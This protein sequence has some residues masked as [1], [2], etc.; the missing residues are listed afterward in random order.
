MRIKSREKQSEIRTYDSEKL[1]KSVLIFAIHMFGLVMRHVVAC[2][3]RKNGYARTVLLTYAL[4][5]FGPTV[6]FAATPQYINVTGSPSPDVTG[7]YEKQP[8]TLGSLGLEYWMRQ[9]GAYY[10]YSDE[11]N[12]NYFWNIDDDTDDTNVYFY[13]SPSYSDAGNFTTNTPSPDAVSSW[14]ACTDCSPAGAG[15][16]T[17][18]AYSP[19]SPEINVLGNSTNINDG[20]TTP[21]PSNGTAFGYTAVS[22]DTISKTFTIENTGGAALTLG[23][24]AVSVSGT[25]S[26]DFTVTTQPASTVASSGTTTFTI[27]FDPSATGTR[28]AQLSIAN[29]DSDENPYNFSIRGGGSDE[30]AVTPQFLV[31]SGISDPSAANG[32]YERQTGTH[33]FF[34]HEYWK[35]E[36]EAYYLYSD[37][38]SDDFYWNIDNDLDD[39]DV[40]F[41]SYDDYN[42][43]ANFATL[44]SPDAI[45]DWR[46][47]DGSGAPEVA[48]SGVTAP[49]INV[50][51]NDTDIATGDTTPRPS[52]DT[53]FGYMTVPS[54]TLS[55]TFT[56]LNTGGDTLTLGVDSVTISGAGASD[57]TITA[58]PAST[59]ASSGTTTF[60]ITFNPSAI[61]TRTAQLSIANDDSDEN[62]YTFSI[63]GGGVDE[64][65]DTPQYIE[66]SGITTPATA[67]GIY[68]KQSD[69]HGYFYH[70]YWKHQTEAYYLYSDAYDDGFYWDIDS[71]FNDDDVL[72]YSDPQAS[73]DQVSPDMV[74]A[75]E[76]YS[77][78]GTPAV[79]IYTTPLP[80]INI[81][82][83]GVDIAD[84]ASS[85]STADDTDFG[86][87]AT[88][89]GTIAK[90]FTIQNTGTAILNLGGTPIVSLTGDSDFSVSA[91]PS[92]SSVAA[93]N[94][95]TFTVTFAPSSDG[96]HTAE[97]SIDNDDGDENPY[98]FTIQG[99]GYTPAAVSNVSAAEADGTYGDGDTIDITITFDDTVNVTGTPQLT[100]E[101]GDTDAVVDYSSGSG[102]AILT[103]IYT[104]AASHRTNDLAYTATAALGL[105]GG[106]ITDSSG[107]IALIALPA[108]G[109]AGSL[110]ANKDLYI[111]SPGIVIDEDDGLSVDESLSDDTFTVALRAQ[112]ENDVVLDLASGDTGEAD[113]SP[114]SL[115]FTST[116]WSTPRTVTITGVNDYL[117]DGDQ[118]TTIGIAVNDAASD[119]HFNGLSGSVSVTTTDDDTAGFTITET[120]GD[121]IVE[122]AGP[123]TDTFTV[124]LDARPDTDVVLS[125]TSGDSTEAAVSPATLTFT[126]S[127]WNTPQTVTVTGVDDT[128][129]DESAAH[130][131]TIAV[132][133]A[134]SDDHFDSLA[135]QTVAVTTINDDYPEISV[136]GT[137]VTEVDGSTLS[138]TFKVSLSDYYNDGNVTVDYKTTDGTAEA[139]SDYTG[140][141]TTVL[142]FEPVG[143]IEKEITVTVLDDDIDEAT[144]EFYLDLSNA[145][146]GTIVTDRAT[147]TIQ[148]DDTSTITIS[149][150]TLAEGDS[151]AA[152]AE[153]T[154]SLACANSR[155]VTVDYAT[156]DNE[157]V[158]G[159]DYSEASGTLTIAAGET[160]GTIQ[161]P[162]TGDILDEDSETFYLDLSNP[163]NAPVS[164]A[165][166]VCTITDDDTAALSIDDT[167]VTEGDSG[168]AAATFTVSLTESTKTV[169][170]DYDTADNTAV[171]GEDYTAVSGG[172]LTF[173]PGDTEQT[174]I[175]NVNGD[176][177]VEG[178][179]SFDVMLSSAVNADI[180]DAQGV[181][182]ITDDDAAGFVVTESGGTTAVS[183]NGTT[184][185]F[186]VV[187]TGQPV[188][189]VQL[190]IT[191]ND[192]SEASLSATALTFTTD[193]WDIP[194]TI[195]VTGEDDEL[196]DG[197][198]A[199]TITVSV[200]DT[201][202]DDHFDGL[203]A[204]TVNVTTTDDEVDTDSDGMPDNWENDH[205]FDPGSPEDA[206][207]DPDGDGLTNQEEYTQ[208]TDPAD[209]DSDGDGYSDGVEV[210]LG[211]DPND[212][213]DIPG[214]PFEMWVDDDWSGLSPGD[215]VG[216]H[217]FGYDAFAL[218]QPAIDASV[219][220]ITV[221]VAAGQYEENIIWDIDLEIEGS[222]V[223]TVLDGNGADTV[224]TTNG[225]TAASKLEGILIRNGQ[226]VN[227]GGMN[228]I[229]STLML[230]NCVF[231][232][233]TAETYGG[234]I[235]NDASDIYLINCTLADNMAGTAGGSIYNTGS[236]PDLRNVI[237]WGNQPDETVDDSGS[238][239]LAN[240]SDIQGGFAGTGNIDSD[241]L[242]YNTTLRD[243]HLSPGSPCLD[244]GDNAAI[245]ITTV[246][247]EA[248][249]RQTGVSIDMG[250]DEYTDSDDDDLPD[251]WEKH[252]WPDGSWTGDN[253]GDDNDGDGVTN[254]GEYQAGLD[255]TTNEPP[256]A[257]IA[258]GQQSVEENVTVSLDGSA[259][260]DI[261]DGIATFFWEQTTADGDRL[262]TITDADQPIATVD[263]PQVDE[264]G[265]SFD[266]SLTVTDPAGQ[267][268][269]S[270]C[271]V[272]ISWKN[273]PPVA[274]AGV[275]QNV[276]PGV[277]VQLDGSASHDSDGQIV[278]YL[279]E[280]VS[281]QTVSL[282]DL[283]SESP[284]F[285]APAPEN[286]EALVFRLTVTDQEGLRATDTVRITIIPGPGNGGGFGCFI[287]TLLE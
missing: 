77:G 207:L 272:N 41:Y 283:S 2:A 161:V 93:G 276:S 67:N 64:T 124:V 238:A 31:V 228:N 24:N 140:I 58:Q 231:T 6:L 205:G 52:D 226:A 146:N 150:V 210:A 139:G 47:L 279:W 51:G 75:W 265:E 53:D 59:V 32:T 196:L 172:S 282:D 164:D 190:G 212:N 147:G 65:A 187:L 55:H 257:V 203:A 36:S 69:R 151:G 28:T 211:N 62:P 27:T 48:G 97:I 5:L 29:D 99:T 255:P 105:N 237:S 178:S 19:G 251:Y 175:I 223:N 170:V 103:F 115:T 189:D 241:P 123:T 135:D 199:S 138:L 145:T 217:L 1:K 23:V 186:T 119:D 98:T 232:G 70:E 182:L 222:G 111:I 240:Y 157:A 118:T 281:G 263:T 155:D 90:T 108:P 76:T 249:D 173:D 260:Y 286:A 174:L 143:E 248:E 57:F 220:G 38:Y 68:V 91:Q 80:E 225:L 165:R 152:N 270:T 46:E 87:A 236:S 171:S 34:N 163:V 268:D 191:S 49:E 156:T 3:G 169:T 183:E 66:V 129:V 88:L 262:L 287:S 244:S 160:A 74:D 266:F 94:E 8:D 13:S 229:G 116:T 14:A 112:P 271:I 185:T 133:D 30:T 194:Q 73:V 26:S 96:D 235:Y 154:V 106:T 22:S 166:G 181:C 92:A 256:V 95:V 50:L 233:N 177:L 162:V 168:T 239:T 100:L 120:D 130:D 42:D 71:D 274:D 144:E 245:I 218:V 209:A 63:K 221:H 198:V 252:Y 109:T 79:E 131:M 202:S 61:G 89:S 261:D 39:N 246:D 114:S 86:S 56:I 44:T 126:S 113:I 184:D 247:F 101:T 15:T 197:T 213:G 273:L 60:T 18:E 122:E 141:T 137:G 148:D 179:E 7:I 132:V 10:I 20:D 264:G 9:D 224:I 21:I 214:D 107:H 230:V 216:G 121:T 193:N 259:S 269:T 153:F 201:A 17:V 234:A 43:E 258:Q 117:I 134:D 16:V 54:G 102:T 83:N 250:A 85:P 280:Q 176:L 149:D 158:A 204:Q 136:T 267:S 84:G 35:H 45:T 128:E 159:N 110:S 208:G 72:F 253:A 227:G 25:A 4:C 40:Y 12:S 215:D 277:R 284:G 278:T 195:T 188:D 242:F 37:E 200:N 33:G 167:S 254:A 275:N 127:D 104:V 78:S 125:V 81:T 206:S 11:Y 142:T 243:Y 192:T 285:T 219:S 180:S 82:G